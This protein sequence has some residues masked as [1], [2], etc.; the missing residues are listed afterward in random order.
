MHKNGTKNARVKVICR[1]LRMDESYNGHISRIRG[2]FSRLS[3]DFVNV[4]QGLFLVSW[5]THKFVNK[6]FSPCLETMQ[7]YISETNLSFSSRGHLLH[8]TGLYFL[9]IAEII[10]RDNKKNL[11]NNQIYF[12]D[13]FINGVYS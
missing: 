6:V 9:P 8:F 10:F 7:S 11:L 12:Q 2:L 4:F 5:Q 1:N 3:V 13:M